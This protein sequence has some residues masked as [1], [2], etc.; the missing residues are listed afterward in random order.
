MELTEQSEKAMNGY[1]K[2]QKDQYLADVWHR[3]FAD[4]ENRG[5]TTEEA[6]LRANEAEDAAERKW[7]E[8]YN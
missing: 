6:I 8:R 5:A 1:Y 3:T 2:F 4:W 7:D